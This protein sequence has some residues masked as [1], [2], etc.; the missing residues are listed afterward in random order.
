MFAK[1]ADLRSDERA[2]LAPD[3][4]G[5]RFLRAKDALLSAEVA[6]GLMCAAQILL[7][8]CFAVLGSVTPFWQFTVVGVAGLLGVITFL[9]GRLA[10][11][12]L[13]VFLGKLHKPL[14]RKSILYWSWWP[15]T[16]SIL[17]LVAILLGI[18]L[19]SHL[20]H[21]NLD[22]YYKLATLQQYRRVE[23]SAV[24]GK[25]VQD[26]GIVNF[27]PGVTVDRSKGSC[28]MHVEGHTYC[29][30]PISSQGQLVGSATGFH[31][32]FAVGVDC[33]TCPG[34]DLDVGSEDFHCGA[35]D[36]PYAIGGVRS[37][38]VERGAQYQQAVEAWKAT[39]AMDASHP[40]FFDWVYDAVN[41]WRYLW[42]EAMHIIALSILAAALVLSATCC[43]LAKVLQSFKRSGSLCPT[44][45]PLPPP[46]LEKTWEWFFPD[47][48][49]HALE[50]R[51][52][53]YA[54]PVAPQPWYGAPSWLHSMDPVLASGHRLDNF[55]TSA[56][57]VGQMIPVEP[58]KTG[59]LAV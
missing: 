3:S 14:Y 56:V 36:N 20:R 1:P 2:R 45:N 59:R 24:S 25:Q 32:F 43:I 27:A 37:L 18:G 38:D 5:I 52:Q 6:A 31:D 19:G 39:Y 34:Q 11:L 57:P 53:Y 26:A 10:V 50:E 30:A 28:M 23:P 42:H 40:L 55:A 15:V 49:H 22:P 41:S 29:V 8:F 46:G 9:L 33:C 21:R 48:L 16:A 7:A 51:H 35:W 12:L 4:Y 17:A 13:S 58:L 54:M 44:D 47:M